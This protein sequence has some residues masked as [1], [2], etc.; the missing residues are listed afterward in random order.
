MV[1][2]L[3]VEWCDVILVGTEYGLQI[4]YGLIISKAG[5]PPGNNWH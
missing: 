3:W 4:I 5:G 1:A 2:W